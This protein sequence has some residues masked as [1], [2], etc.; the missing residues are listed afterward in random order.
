MD[1]ETK[2]LLIAQADRLVE[3]I[4]EK[5]SRILFAI[6]N[7]YAVAT[8]RVKELEL[9]DSNLRNRLAS[10]ELRLI[11]LETGRPASAGTDMLG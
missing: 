6:A 1:D 4:H 11:R 10:I 8:E 7:A 9:S 3:R 2:A 5:D